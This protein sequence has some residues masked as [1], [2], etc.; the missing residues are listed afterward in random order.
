MHFPEPM[1]PF[2]IV[3]ADSPFMSLGQINSRIFVV[4]PALGLEHRV[5]NG[6][7]YMS[8]NSVLDPEEIGRRAEIFQAR[9]GH[10]FRNWNDL[11]ERWVKKVEKVIRALE[12]LEVPEMGDLE[13]EAVVSEGV[14]YGSTHRLLVAYDRLLESIDL[15]W[16]YHFEFLHLGYAAY[17]NFTQLCRQHFP[18]ITDQAMARMVGGVEVTLFRPDE[19]LKRLAGEALRLGIGDRVKGV[20]GMGELEERLGG[21]E[22]GRGWLEDLRHTMNPWFYFSYGN[23]FYHHHRSWIDDPELPLT[24]IGSYVQRLQAGEEIARPLEEVSRERDRISAEYRDLL[25][26][27]GARQAFDE[28]LG[29]SRL[30]FPY[31][32][33][34]NFYVEHWYHTLFWNKVR[35]FGDLLVRKGFFDEADD[36]F[37]LQRHEV[38]DALVDLRLAWASG[39]V[40]AGGSHW[41]PIVARRRAMIRTMRGWVPPPALG[42]AP[43]SIQEPM[44]IMLWGIT[45]ERVQAWLEGAGAA[46]RTLNGFAGSPGVAEGRARVVIDVRELDRLE[47][48]EI[49]VA[50]VT[51]PSWTPVFGRIKAAVSAIGGVMS[52]AAIVAREYG[53]PAVVGTGFAT[54]TIKTGQRIR[55]DGDKGVVTLLD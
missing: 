9:A 45:T 16:Q 35:E 7:V 42:P 55:V 33:S 11:Y 10:Y 49:L 51:V 32:E 1:F 44:T 48:G 46:G 22:P 47:E 40:P 27:D 8:S 28:A 31:V 12:S 6:Y 2:D 34:H 3:T 13:D 52:H 17:L 37:Y 23:G 30:V 19:E 53:L 20:R 29:L 5:L 4:P 41:K 15:I 36:V 43:D 50:P 38:H 26:E 54:S 39:G 25:L 14:G 21:E 18:E 24:T